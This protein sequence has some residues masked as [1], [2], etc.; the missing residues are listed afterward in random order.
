MERPSA[1]Q[2]GVSLLEVTAVVLLISM[3]VGISMPTF[4]NLFEPRLTKETNKIA[5][6]IK[7]L[8]TEAIL[9]GE[10]YEIIFNPSKSTYHVLVEDREY[11][12]KYGV[13]PKHSKPFIIDSPIKVLSIKRNMEEQADSFMSFDKIEFDQI[14]GQEFRLRIDSTGFVDMFTIRLADKDNAATLSTVNI[15]GKIKIENIKSF[16]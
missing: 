10:N 12:G 14:F 4:S 5:Y 16:I 6:L 11:R 2:Q 9:F 15:M 7:T 1:K 13:H 8:R 3:I